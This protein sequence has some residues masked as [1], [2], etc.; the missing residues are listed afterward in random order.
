M[1]KKVEHRHELLENPEALKEKLVGAETSKLV[2]GIGAVIALA[3]AGYFGFQYYK[4]G[5]NNEA[6]AEMFQAVHYF[7]A[8]SL[9]QALNGDGNNLGFLDIINDYSIT[10]AGNLAH[11]YTGVIYL[12]QGKFAEA[13]EHLED[14]KASDLLVQPRVYSLIGDTYMEEKNFDEAASFYN[15]AANYDANKF[16]SP[17]YLLKEA[18][19]YEKLNKLDKA[20]DT[21][22]KI[23]TQYWD[24]PESQKATKLKARLNS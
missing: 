3:A 14:F 7:E 1:A 10:E 8:D 13:R 4:S 24:T 19:A 2:L 9:D 6:Q 22:E 15:K 5:K 18:L 20:R 21:Y 11:Y 17:A 23:I 16:F 12:K